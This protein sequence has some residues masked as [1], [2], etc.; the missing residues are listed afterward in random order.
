METHPSLPQTS[1][2]DV[3]LVEK[4]AVGEGSTA[5]SSLSKARNA[6]AQVKSYLM[7][8]PAGQILKA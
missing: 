1:R 6:P 2:R 8:H 4:L 7:F 3:E 5:A